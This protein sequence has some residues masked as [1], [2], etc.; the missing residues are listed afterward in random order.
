MPLALPSLRLAL[1]PTAFVAVV[2]TMAPVRAAASAVSPALTGTTAHA[3]PNLTLGSAY[4]VAPANLIGG[5]FYESFPGY[6]DFGLTIDGALALAATGD[7]DPALKGIV[8]F[9][10]DAGKDPHGNTVNT[11]TGI[12]T[13][14]VSGG[15]L[16]EEAL[17]TEATGYNPRAFGGHNL[18]TALNAAVCAR[19]SHG[20][21]TSCAGP[22]NYTY[23]S[24]VFDQALG[25]IAQLRA[26][27]TSEAAAPIRYLESLRNTDG[28]FPSLIP[29][30]HDQDV[31]STAM[32][33]MALALVPGATAAADVRSGVAWVASRQVSDGGFP[34]ASGNSVN[35]AGLA[36]QALTLAGPEYKAR[37]G[38][39]LGFL[40]HEQ[41]SNGGFDVAAGQH[42][43]NVRASTQA[44]GGAVG[45]SFGTLHRSLTGTSTPPPSPPPQH[46]HT[47][48]PVPRPTVTVTQTASAASATPTPGATPAHS[49]ATAIPTLSTDLP[50]LT[51]VSHHLAKLDNTGDDSS[52]TTGLW[53]SVLGVAVAAIVVIG[54]LFVRRRRLYPGKASP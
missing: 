15:S 5:H 23:A 12:G 20:G 2:A 9:L 22:G 48:K 50:H 27:Q 39:A 29:D 14:Y 47:K 36:I 17:L 1:L 18:I 49:A 8:T 43:S 40:A 32:A 7:Q 26:K 54:L 33:V 42:G 16:G 44:L 31:D 41:N 3:G 53:W 34:G 46:G 19:A 10:D 24:S 30:S 4:L 38:S 37:I 45:T 52:L 21:N 6:A 25:I 35:S 51:P 13:R 28:S 11:W